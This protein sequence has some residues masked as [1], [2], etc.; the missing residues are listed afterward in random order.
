MTFINPNGTFSFGRNLLPSTVGFDRLFSTLDEAMNIPE[1]VLTTFPPYN[2]AKVGED[3]YVIELAVAG[4]KR[5]DIDI[6]LE[7]NKLTIQGNAKKDEENTGKVYYHNGIA[8]RRF[9][10]VFT[11]ADTVVVKSADLVDGMLI[12]ELENVIPENKKPRKISLN[13]SKK[14]LLQE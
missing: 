5:E 3:K 12:V 2:I 8:L 6:T 10:R 14:V 4:F 11:L 13:S 1:K 7:D 9:T